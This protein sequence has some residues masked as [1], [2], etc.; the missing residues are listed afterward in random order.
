MC[1]WVEV[2]SELAVHSHS[3][4]LCRCFCG[5]CFRPLDGS[6]TR[7]DHDRHGN[8]YNRSGGD[9]HKYPYCDPGA[10]RDSIGYQYGHTSRDQY[11]D[12]VSY[13]HIDVNSNDHS[14]GDDH[15]HCNRYADSSVGLWLDGYKFRSL[16]LRGKY[17]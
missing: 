13:E 14:N 6:G 7:P 4:S 15:R 12:T 5:A 17:D 1:R 8:R 3:Q 2:R 16:Y 9:F 10:H 11:G